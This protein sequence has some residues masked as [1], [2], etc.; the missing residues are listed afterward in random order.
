MKERDRLLARLGVRES[1]IVHFDVA[2]VDADK[3]WAL[4][5]FLKGRVERRRLKGRTKVYRYPGL[6]HEGGFRLG[7]S[8]YLL[9]PDHASRL[10]GRLRDLGI[11]HRWWDVYTPG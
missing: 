10:I 6:L 11:R 8:V 5:R 9:S 3:R 2:K 1:T 7:Q 4:Q